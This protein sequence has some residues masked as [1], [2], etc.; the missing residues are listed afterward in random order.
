MVEGQRPSRGEDVRMR[1]RRRSSNNRPIP[2]ITGYFSPRYV[3][4][5]IPWLGMAMGAMFAVLSIKQFHDN[6]Y[7]YGPYLVGQT[8][9]ETLYGFNAPQQVRASAEAPW[10][11]P[12]MNGRA[13]FIYPEWRYRLPAGSTVEIAFANGRAEHISCGSREMLVTACPRSFGV[14]LGDSEDHVIYTLGAPTR[15]IYRGPAKTL[16]YPEL[17]LSLE[18]EQF[19]VRQIKVDNRGGGLSAILRYLRWSLP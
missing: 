18:L 14:G 12:Q 5:A 6:F 9:D 8:T 15:E 11:P 10:A 2:N 3:M 17:G 7:F 13:L 1:R 16:V 4:R 19:R